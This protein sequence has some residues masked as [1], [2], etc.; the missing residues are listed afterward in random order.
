MEGEARRKGE[1]KEEEEEEVGGG[2]K[3]QEEEKGG[4][5][6]WEEQEGGS[7][8]KKEEE[9]EGEGEGVEEETETRVKEDEG[10]ED[11]ED[12]GGVAAVTEIR[13]DPCPGPSMRTIK[14]SSSGRTTKECLLGK[15]R[16]GGTWTNGPRTTEMLGWEPL[17]TR[18]AR[19]DQSP[20]DNVRL[21]GTSAATWASGEAGGIPLRPRLETLL[22]TGRETGRVLGRGPARGAGPG[23]GR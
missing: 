20:L 4:G 14:A 12:G 9:Q 17:Y 22:G 13:S 16:H 7:G 5:G 19:T 21:R 3:S 18:R 2:E 23:A 8:P 15:T 6:K 10:K 1:G 11:E